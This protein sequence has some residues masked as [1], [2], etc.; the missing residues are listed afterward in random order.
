MDDR[1]DRVIPFEN[2]VCSF[3]ERWARGK[4]GA[5]DVATGRTVEFFHCR[6]HMND[7]YAAMSDAMAG[8][9]GG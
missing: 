8:E 1:G 4:I 5:R 2:D 7:A 9:A 6:E 3:C